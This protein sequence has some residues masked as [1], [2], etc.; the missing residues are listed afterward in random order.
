MSV[1]I[2]KLKK[3]VN[4]EVD[5]QLDKDPFSSLPLRMRIG[6]FML[7]GSFLIGY[8]VPIVLMIIS[9]RNHQF[10]SGVAK[11]T[12]VYSVCWITGFIGL[13]LAGKDC[14]K[15]PIYFLAKF[16]KVLF[17]SYFKKETDLD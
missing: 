6:I 4:S 12:V 10:L 8:G 7:M 5:K 9:G 15:Y 1:F 2:S 11:G 13:T 14:I 16:L 3:W 17:P